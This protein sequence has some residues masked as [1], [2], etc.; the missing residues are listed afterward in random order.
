MVIKFDPEGRVVMVFGRKQE[1]SDEDTGPLKHPNP[2]LPAVD[3]RFRQVT[4]VAWDAAGNTYISD[5]YINSRVAKV[6]KDG[7]WLKSWGERGNGARPVQHA[8]LRSRPTPTAT[9]MSPIAAT[10]ASRCSTA[11]ASSCARSPSTCR[12]RRDA[13]PAI[14]NMPDEA[15]IAD[16]TSR[17]ARRGRSASRRRRTRCSTVRT[18]APAASTSSAS[19]AR[20]WACSANPASS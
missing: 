15:T 14:G 13:K 11:T 20:C 3:G 16:G 6:D 5:G 4:D 10:A 17:R 1:A 8:A 2:P 19:T 18:P 12:C 7:D 9:S